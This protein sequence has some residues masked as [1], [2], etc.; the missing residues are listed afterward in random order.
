MPHDTHTM[1][2]GELEAERRA[3][4]QAMWKGLSDAAAAAAFERHRAISVELD[5]RQG[6]RNVAPA[7]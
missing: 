4:N 7:A 6:K 3:L 1:S 5:R 2:T